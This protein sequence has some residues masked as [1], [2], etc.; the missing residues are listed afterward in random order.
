MNEMINLL[1]CT[2]RDGGYV[3]DWKFGHDVIASTYKRLE[4]AGV[5][6]IEVGFLD[7]RREFDINRSINP[8]T[9]S[10]DKIFSG[11]E[12][13]NSVPLAMIDYGTCSIENIAPCEESFIDGI[14]VIFK[15][16]KIEDALPFCKEIK[17]KGY[18][19]FIQAIS[20]TDYSDLEMLQY[21][22]KINEIQPYAFS[23]VDTYGLLDRKELSNYFYIMDRNLLPEIAIGYHGHNNFQLAFSNSISFLAFDTTRQRIVDST[24]YGMGK[25]AGNCAS[26]LIALHMNKKYEK[27]YD[28][29]QF[30]EIFDSNLM[31]FYKEKY[32]GYKYNFYISAMQN[33]HPNYVQ[34]LI[35]KKTLSVTSINNILSRIPQSQKLYF[36]EKLIEDMYIDY[37]S[38][39][40]NDD[41]SISAIKKEL[42]NRNVVVIGLGNS[43]FEKYDCINSF[44]INNSCVVITVNSYIELYNPNFIFMSNAKRYR[45]LADEYNGSS[46]HQ[47]ILTS[48]IDTLDLK[49]DYVLNYSGLL[50]YNQDR[51]DNALLLCLAMLIKAGV[52]KANLAGFDGFTLQGDDYYDD[53]YIFGGNEQYMVDNNKAIAKGIRELS[54][55]ITCNFL[56]DSLYLKD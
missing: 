55:Q 48:N 18:K 7:D 54:K 37:Q 53:K 35:D 16:N 39:Q 44:I 45:K 50:E 10:F 19:L 31:P 6:F 25:S 21:I 26:E 34:F 24:V 17:K 46:I 4:S 52:K 22:K 20:I 13:G 14:R 11:C 40:I 36:E 43:A 33:C 15:K 47:L 8:T 28:V 23:I 5:E 2:L 51:N 49:S 9:E 56:T 38:K 30:L 42:E 41:S 12:K 3:N 27:K 1:D 32:W 29:N